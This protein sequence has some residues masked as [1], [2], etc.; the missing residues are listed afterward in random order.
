[1][2]RTVFILIT[3]QFFGNED[4]FDIIQAGICLLFAFK[5]ID[6]TVV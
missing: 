4:M 1:M 6:Q 2:Q 5:T 3:S